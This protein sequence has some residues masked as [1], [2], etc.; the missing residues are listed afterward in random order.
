MSR[1]V[2]CSVASCERPAEKRGLCGAHYGRLKRGGTLRPEEPIG[3]PHNNPYG[4]A[5][6]RLPKG[7]LLD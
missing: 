7:G 4:P 3:R 1:W 5:F 6:F 2:K